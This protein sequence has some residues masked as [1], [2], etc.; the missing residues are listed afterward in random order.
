MAKMG[1]LKDAYT[2][3]S[4]LLLRATNREVVE[5]FPIDS[6]ENVVKPFNAA[7]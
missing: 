3:W 6:T 1:E 7:K 2:T 5:L 4:K